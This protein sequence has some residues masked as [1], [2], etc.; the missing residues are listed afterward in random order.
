MMWCI[1]MSGCFSSVGG[2][3]ERIETA[4]IALKSRLDKW[5]KARRALNKLEKLARISDLARK[6]MGER[7]GKL[8][9]VK[10]AEAWGYYFSL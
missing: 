3:E 4:R 7:G 10:G 2:Q 6:M 9:K 1:V 8:L 5:Y